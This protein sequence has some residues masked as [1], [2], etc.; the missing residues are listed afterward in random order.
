MT[1]Y[2]HSRL[3][4]FEQCAFKYKLKYLDKIK[5]ES[6]QS[7][8]AFMGSLVHETL[9][10]VYTDKKF[11]KVLTLDEAKKYLTNL[12]KKN[13]ND[14]II[15]VRKGYGPDNYL[16]MAISFIEGYYRNYYP[17][18]DGITV[19]LEERVV[20]NLDA[21]GKYQL[22]GYI[23][24]LATVGSEYHIIDYKTNSHL[25]IQ[26]QVDG[27]R[28][29]ALYQIAVHNNYKDAKKV[30]LK[31]HFLAFGKVLISERSPE[32]LE[33]LKKE[34]IDLIKT[35][36]SCKE[37]K[38]KVSALCDWCEFRNMCPEWSHA[39][40]LEGKSVNE[41]LTDDGVKLVNEFVKASDDAKELG[42]K[43]DKIK[44]ALVKFA[45]DKGVNVV[46]GS[47]NKVKVITYPSIHFP[48]KGSPDRA[49]LVK[50]LKS[51]GDWEFVEDLDTYELAKMINNA[52][53]S[54]DVIKRI[55][56]LVTRDETSRLYPSK[57]N[58]DEDLTK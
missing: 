54:E 41:Y 26:D 51:S 12:W 27:D 11:Q 31:W 45:K 24:R 22:Q 3:S 30:V 2:S 17:F 9:E 32:Q 19:G 53:L 7:I 25:K 42:A 20:I 46:F 15:I 33:T 38:T 52:E 57:I 28:Q 37:F 35:I 55:A 58:R 23:D 10:K 39:Y 4:T 34:T 49:E 40:S 5:P 29:L 18:D 6:F 50:L 43:L 21:E 44:E 47:N 13:W 48:K 8:E 56:A 16:A 14:E 1:L 36:E